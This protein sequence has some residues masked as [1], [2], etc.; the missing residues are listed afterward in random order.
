MYVLPLPELTLNFQ[1]EE[2][3]R[4]VIW[5][6]PEH[7][8]T[9]TP[10]GLTQVFDMCGPELEMFKNKFTEDARSMIAGFKYF[11]IFPKTTLPTH[12]DKTRTSVLFFSLNPTIDHTLNFK[13][14]KEGETMFSYKYSNVPALVN[15]EMWHEAVNNSMEYRLAVIAYSYAS[16]GRFNEF[17]KLYETKKLLCCQDQEEYSFPWE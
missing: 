3:L 8:W 1:F 12:K 11:R 16:H 13:N 6:I 17:Q 9:T 2:R 10:S 4:T 7:L 14:R 5:D 15:V